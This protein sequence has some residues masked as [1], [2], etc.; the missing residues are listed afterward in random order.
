MSEPWARVLLHEYFYKRFT[1]IDEE[2][3]QL[4]YT[5]RTKPG[6]I[7]AIERLWQLEVEKHV[8]M[9]VYMDLKGMA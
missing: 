5:I 7:V 2:E 9:G 6:R 4:I 3:R 1:E 8:L